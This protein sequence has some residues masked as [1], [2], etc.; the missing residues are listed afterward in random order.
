MI[1]S[2]NGS[3]Q[4]GFEEL[5]CQLAY[6]EK[7]NDG[8]FIRLGKPDAG[9]ECY[10]VLN[11]GDEWGWQAKFFLSSLSTTQWSQIDKSIKRALE[12]RPNLKKYIVAIPID[13]P[14]A[15]IKGKISMLDKWINKKKEW[16]ALARRKGMEVEFEAWWSSDLIEKISP[17]EGLVYYWFNIEEF[18]SKWCLDVTKQAILDLGTRYTPE[19]NII[20]EIKDLFSGLYR[21]EFFLNQTKGIFDRVFTAL[22]DLSTKKYLGEQKERIQELSERLYNTYVS[23][24]FTGTKSIQW[25]LLYS[26]L[27]Q[28][29][30]T[31]SN[32]AKSIINDKRV[33]HE[34]T[35]LVQYL[36]DLIDYTQSP[37]ATLSNEPFLLI[38]GDAGA[39]KSHLLADVILE[40][41]ARSPNNFLLLGQHFVTDDNPW[42]QI[43]K[44]LNITCKVDEF[45]G[46]L[47]AKGEAQQERLIVYIDAINEGRGVN[48]WPGNV[49]SFVALIQKY[50]WLG[51]VLSIRTTYMDAIFPNGISKLPFTLYTHIGFANCV[52]TAA[53]QFFHYYGLV[54]PNIPLLHPEFQNPLLLKLLCEAISKSEGCSSLIGFKG[55]STIVYTYLDSVN[56]AISSKLNIPK[57]IKIVKKSLQKI[58]EEMAEKGVSELVFLDAFVLLNKLM[59]NELHYPVK[60]LLTQL[61]SEGV[62]IKN[63]YNGKLN[64]ERISF[65]FE[66]VKDFI[67]GDYLLEKSIKDD[68]FHPCEMLLACFKDKISCIRNQGLLE[69]LAILMPEKFDKEIYELLED[70][71]HTSVVQESFIQS[72]KWRELPCLSTKNSDYINNIWRSKH[73]INFFLKTIISL[74]AQPTNCLNS[75]YL[76][77]IMIKQSLAIRDSWWTIFLCNEFYEGSSIWLLVQWGLNVNDENNFLQESIKLASICLAWFLSS[78]NNFLRDKATKALINLLKDR[79]ST[80]I[81]ILKLFEKVNDPYI[82]ERLF[83]VALGCSMYAKEK[84]KLINL[85]NY[86]YGIIFD[87]ENEIYP[88][89]LLRDYARSIIE[90]TLQIGFD[91]SIDVNKIRPPYKSRMPEYFPATEEIDKKYK[92][93]SSEDYYRAQNQIISSM[94]TEYG[95]GIAQYGDFGR[96]TFQP[97]ISAWN[98]NIDNMSNLAVDL[99]FTKYG[100]DAKL[101]GHF[102]QNIDSGSVRHSGLERIGKKYQWMVFHEL[103]ARISDNCQMK[104]HWNGTVKQYEGPW[105]PF[106]RDID[107]SIIKIGTCA[108]SDT[109]RAGAINYSDWGLTDD[110]WIEM[111]EDI[112]DFHSLINY[113]DQNRKSWMVLERMDTW[114]EPKILGEKEFVK[115]KQLY[116]QIRSYLIPR[117]CREDFYSWGC[118]KNFFGRWMPEG[119]Q[120]YSV[121]YNEYYWSPAYK[122]HKEIQGQADV[123][124]TDPDTKEFICLGIPTVETYILE[125]GRDRSINE[126]ITC[127]R[128]CLELAEGVELKRGDTLGYQYEMNGNLI[129]FDP[130]I[131]HNCDPILLMSKEKLL[132]YLDKN[133]LSIVWTVIGEKLI[134]DNYKRLVISETGYLD[135]QGALVSCRTFFKR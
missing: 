54:A 4:E 19:N 81:E 135:D 3:Q 126:T 46:S 71:S 130:S 93:A 8:H 91:L 33:Y 104:A 88:H 105:E 61:I 80:L 60:D 116:L 35:K 90:Y 113:S 115:R 56:L 68:G 9:V 119:D 38:N 131:I 22:N 49:N 17:H 58:I 43:L 65:S 106:V 50:E 39:G 31:I 45:L 101:H 48:F 83:A 73:S 51:L 96:Y 117:S 18:T 59:Q 120:L 98:V 69:I 41:N 99:I 30:E 57:E 76:H 26:I 111:E 85:S 14:D 27:N 123:D 86:I 108:T 72:L 23:T 92:L 12:T 79:I 37:L 13:P 89:I 84:Y 7:V 28:L 20:L 42:H 110:A 75:L 34:L 128:P 78:T 107:P 70:F 87:V 97:A 11:N 55:M 67:L 29:N 122:Y 109:E 63:I 102:D 25:H 129:V 47:N 52:D 132:E 32:L 15:R 134:L 64:E 77:E 112:P 24:E 74:C 100:Y 2:I 103:L 5:V 95:R 44:K 53:Q 62:L 82:Y 114:M 121:F 127:L 118:K 1:R 125:S 21:D 66:R 16:T 40:R 133:D 94:A 10:W 124:I 6:K 36:S